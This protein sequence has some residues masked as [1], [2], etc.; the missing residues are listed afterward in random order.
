MASTRPTTSDKAA[1]SPE[2]PRSQ[3]ALEPL[4]ERFLDYLA[5]SAGRSPNTLL[6]YRRDLERYRRF[7][8]ANAVAEPKA[9]DPQ[10]VGTFV[11]T[12]AGEMLAPASIARALSAVKSFHRYLLHHDLLTANPARSIKTPRLPR[13]LPGVLSVAQVRKMLDAASHDDRSGIRNRAILAVL[14]GCGLRVSEAANLGVD[15]LDFDEGFVRVR[16]KGSRERLVPLGATTSAAVRQ[17]L[18]GPRREWEARHQADHLFYNRQGKRLTR[19]SIWKIVR[20]SAQRIGLEKR[21]SPH[22][23]RHSFATHLLS[24]GAD[25]RSVQAMLGHSSVATTQ[26]YTHLDRAHL[27]AVHRRFHPLEAPVEQAEKPPESP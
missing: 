24:A 25:L 11:A 20:G 18:E 12:L 17:Y 10:T 23:F 14:Y 5:L 1:S 2:D 13:K 27:S 19:M 4:I 7:C 21:I 16:G 6:G 15:D 9:I 8:A 3:G 26:I 22:T